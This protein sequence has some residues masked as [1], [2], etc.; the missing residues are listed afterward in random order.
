MKIT[1]ESLEDLYITQGLSVRECAKK[2]GL[3]SH[4][5]ISWRLKKFGIKDRPARFQKG[6]TFNKNEKGSESPFYKGGK[7]DQKCKAC[8][9]SFKV[10]PSQKSAFTRCDKCKRERFDLTGSKFGLLEVIERHG[11]AKGGHIVWWCR[12]ECGKE[13]TV[14]SADLKSGR[15]RSCGCEQGLKGEKNPNW[16]EKIKVKCC[17][18][19]KVMRIHPCKAEL[20]KKHFCKNSNCYGEWLKKTEARK[21]AKS[22]KWIG[23]PSKLRVGIQIEGRVTLSD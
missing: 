5:G 15:T 20:Y 7:I 23:G 19:K 21:G 18:C 12:C 4:G 1:K 6:N 16:E 8:G 3:P 11:S 13:T 22:P 14:R 10:F 2:L 17:Y 9:K